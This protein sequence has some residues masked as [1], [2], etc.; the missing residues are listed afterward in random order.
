MSTVDNAA[1]QAKEIVLRCPKG[2]KLAKRFKRSA[3]MMAGR[4][5]E[6]QNF[7]MRSCGIA[8]HEAEQ[9]IREQQRKNRNKSNQAE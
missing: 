1:T 2:M 7:F 8:V 9:K 5:K 3:A 4:S 6:D